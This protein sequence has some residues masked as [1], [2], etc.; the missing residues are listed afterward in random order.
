MTLKLPTNAST[1]L[2]VPQRPLPIQAQPHISSCRMSQLQISAK[3][4][5]PS[6]SRYP[7]EKSSIPRISA[8]STYQA[9]AMPPLKPTLSLA[10][11]IHPSSRSNNCATMDA[12]SFSPK[13][14]AKSFEKQSSCWKVSD[15]QPQGYGLFQPAQ[16]KYPPN[17]PQH[18]HPMPPTMHTKRP[19]KRN[20]YN[21]CI[22][23]RSAR[24]RQRGF[25]PLIT[26]NSPHGQD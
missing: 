23:V 12:M 11:P 15:I 10:W 13:R 25:E 6:T 3:P 1:L 8:T 21:S 18:L 14:N 17:P 19:P 4:S 5:T 16:R 9:W 20:S 26:I 24:Q 2:L 7:M 22:N